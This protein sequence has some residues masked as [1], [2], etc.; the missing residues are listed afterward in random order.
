MLGKRTMGQFLGR[1]LL[2]DDSPECRTT[3]SGY[4][5]E[6]GIETFTARG[7]SDA[8]AILSALKPDVTTLDLDMPDGASFDLIEEVI[9]AGSRCFVVTSQD[10][11]EDRIRAFTLGADDCVTRTINLEEFYLRMRNILMNRRQ[12]SVEASNR[13]IDF[14]GVK[15]TFRKRELLSQRDETPG[16]ELSETELSMLQL[17]TE[18]MDRVVDKDALAA[19]IDRRSTLPTV[20]ALDMAVSRLRTKLKSSSVGVEVRSVRNVGYI[21]S[22]RSLD[23]ASRW[24]G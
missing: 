16:A 15:V 8:S 14:N 22:R 23:A 18:N 5:S 12:I 21:M 4:L 17:L 10:R 9:R 24:V 3:L 1:A 6:R 2:V 19:A 20:R 11:I 7:V 13:V